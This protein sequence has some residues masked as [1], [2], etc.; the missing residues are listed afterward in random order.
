M[1]GTEYIYGAVVQTEKEKEAVISILKT[2][3]IDTIDGKPL[4][5]AIFVGRLNNKMIKDIH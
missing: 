2:M 5:E 4:E 3:D 1:I